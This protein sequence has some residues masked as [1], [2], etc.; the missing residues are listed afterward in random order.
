MEANKQTKLEFDNKANLENFIPTPPES[1]I[2]DDII[3]ELSINKDNNGENQQIGKDNDGTDKQIQDKK[4]NI[5]LDE[6]EEILEESKPVRDIKSDTT[7][8]KKDAIET[9]QDVLEDVDNAESEK[10]I[11]S[12]KKIVKEL[13]DEGLIKEYEGDKKIED[14]SIKEIRQLLKDNINTIKE[15]ASET[16]IT[17]FVETLPESLQLAIKYAVDVEDDTNLPQ[18]LRM[19]AD[20]HEGKNILDTMNDEAVVAYVLKN[21]GMEDDEIELAIDTYKKKGVLAEKAKKAKEEAKELIDNEF[22][23]V[24]QDVLEKKEKVKKGYEEFTK[25]ISEYINQIN[26]DVDKKEILEYILKPDT[27]SPISGKQT[28]KFYADLEKY[29]FVEQK[30]DLI[31][32]AAWLLKD[33]EGYKRWI[34]E[35]VKANVV[36]E[37]LH[38]RLKKAT[39]KISKN[40][41]DVGIMGKESNVQI[42]KDKDKKEGN[43]KKFNWDVL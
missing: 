33:P 4:S 12:I 14:Y 41:P 30:P 38:P 2:D 42:N 21:K 9:I 37:E 5:T 13:V 11:R 39:D 26:S 20:I 18:V 32:E 22:N 43:R 34:Q 1:I 24:E 19:I 36:A 8:A 31:F 7:I 27:Q 3:Q 25:K 35:K 28:T 10:D 6:F 16:A 23:K 29:Q 17:K 40:Q 15:E